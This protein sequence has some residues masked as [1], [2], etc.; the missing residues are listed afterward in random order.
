M[1]RSVYAR[2]MDQDYAH[3]HQD[4]GNMLIHIVA[5]PAFIY[6]AW[7]VLSGV[8]AGRWVGALFGLGAIGVSLVLQ[9]IGHNREPNPSLPFDGPG[10]FAKRI[11]SEQFYRFPMY[12]LTGGWL[13]AVRSARG[14]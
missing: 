12:V 1:G 10:D 2:G 7:L 8:L 5:V 3:F 6:G 11:L 13:K 9:R 4:R 14:R